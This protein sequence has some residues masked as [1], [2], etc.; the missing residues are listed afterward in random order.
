MIPRRQTAL[1]RSII[2]PSPGGKFTHHPNN[3]DDL[4][5]DAHPTGKQV[6]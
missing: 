4:R 1:R 6:W 5:A 3:E 2:I